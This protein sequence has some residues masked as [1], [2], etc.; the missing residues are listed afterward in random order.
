MKGGS[1]GGPDT[2]QLTHPSELTQIK[3]PA[4]A[5]LRVGGDRSLFGC[6]VR[7]GARVPGRVG[8]REAT[9]GTYSPYSHPAGIH[10]R[11]QMREGVEWVKCVVKFACLDVPVLPLPYPVCCPSVVSVRGTSGSAE[12]LSPLD[13]VWIICRPSHRP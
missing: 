7:F 6:I 1:L 13:P 2:V 3:K 9:R 10:M 11:I 8:Q 12:S 5:L 4:S